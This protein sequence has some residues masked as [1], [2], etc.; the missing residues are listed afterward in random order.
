[1]C[2]KLLFSL[3]HIV[4]LAGCLALL[5]AC[6]KEIRPLPHFD[7]AAWKADPNGCKGQRQRVWADFQAYQNELTGRDEN[8][9]PSLLGP[10]D[11]KNLLERGQ[12]FYVYYVQ[13]PSVCRPA[14]AG[15]RHA[16]LVRVNATGS[17]SE[18]S[19]ETN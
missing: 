12:K 3:T 19:E 14:A 15:T 9:L 5:S 7:S 10:P 8:D 11:G 6:R 18:V 4:C 13:N 16:I 1:M 2:S 17:V